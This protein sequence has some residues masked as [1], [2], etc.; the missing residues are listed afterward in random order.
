QVFNCREMRLCGKAPT[1]VTTVAEQYDG[2]PVLQLEFGDLPWGCDAH[3]EFSSTESFEKVEGSIETSVVP[4]TCNYC[5]RTQLTTCAACAPL[6]SNEQII[7]GQVIPKTCSGGCKTCASDF[8]PVAHGGFLNFYSR[9]S[10]VCGQPCSQISQVKVCNNGNWTGDA[11]FSFGQ[12]NDI[13]DP[14]CTC[15]HPITRA[16]VPSDSAPITL[17]KRVSDCGKT[18]ADA[19]QKLVVSCESGVFIDSNLNPLSSA[20]LATFNSLS[21]TNGAAVCAASASSLSSASSSSAG[22]S[23]FI[24]KLVAMFKGEV[25]TA[26]G[27][28]SCMAGATDVSNGAYYTFYDTNSGSCSNKCSTHT[29]SRQCVNGA[30][31]GNSAYSY[32][33]CNDVPCGCFLPIDN[34]TYDSGSTVITIYKTSTP[35]CGQSC[36]GAGVSLAMR[37]NSG[38]WVDAATSVAV[39][40]S[41]FTTYSAASCSVPKCDCQRPGRLT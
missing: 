24:G 40:V 28:G 2:T 8:G 21:C 33:T 15:Q 3:V 26:S 32:T 1:K 38:T 27:P 41:A 11:K 30:F 34:K 16:P 13:K 9:Q 17:T 20:Q 29:L 19:S 6:T 37:C 23:G 7:K 31:A 35:S 36:T 25:S 14:A 12:C 18:C 22:N 10:P 4:P 39:P 5:E